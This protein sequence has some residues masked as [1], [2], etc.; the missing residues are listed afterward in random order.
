MKITKIYEDA[1]KSCIICNSC[2][3]CEGLCAVFPAMEKKREFSLTD[4]DYLANLCHQCSECFY[5]CQ[6]APPHE[7]NV[8]IPKQFA[9]LRQ[10]SYEKYS[11]P[12][13]LGS[14]FGKNAVLTT[15]VLILCLFFG[16]WSASSYDG[17]NTNGNFFAVVSY[18]YMVS[19]F[20][21]VSLLV[22]IALFGGIIKFY[23]AIE[24]KN[25]NFKV[26]VQSIKDAMTL[27][28]L[29]GY[30]NEGCTYPNEKRS[31][32]RKT[33]HHF[34]AYGFLFCFIATCLGAIYHHFLNL[35]APY[36]I[37]QLP[38]IFG[39]LGGIMLCIGSLG[40]FVLKCIADKNIID[41]QSV[42]MDY[43]FI[44]ML[45]LVSFTGILLMFLKHSFFLSYALWFHLSCVLAFFIMMPYSKFIHMFYRFIA[46]LKYNSEEEI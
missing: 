16:F 41:E 43:T 36:D 6:Y 27:K 5:D 44:F 11:F 28:Y 39:I 34:T 29:G 24:I 45:F 10:Y 33:F 1:N 7:F 9:A 30:K 22:C 20:S 26:F 17:E 32:I 42:S 12:N 40:L 13:F 18:E 25:V 8:S 2:R 35:V 21:I 19:V 4:M 15:I 38:K 31:N 37:T 23:R 14:A 46:L 3:Y